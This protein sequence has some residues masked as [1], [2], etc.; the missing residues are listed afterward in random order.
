MAAKKG[1]LGALHRLVT[2]AYT[3][4]IEMDMEEDIFN[5]SL[6]AGAVKFL[7]DNEITADIKEDDDLKTMRDK[8]IQAAEERRARNAGKLLKAVGYDCEDD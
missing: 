5:P 2:E 7:K 8:L 6:L 4:G 3:K 1:E